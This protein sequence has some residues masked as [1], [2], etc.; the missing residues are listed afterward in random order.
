VVKEIRTGQVIQGTVTKAVDFGVFVDV[1]EGVEGLLHVSEIPG[2]EGAYR[3]LEPGSLIA[4]RVLDINHWRRR[5]SL[6]LQQ[7]SQDSPSP[8]VDE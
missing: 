2:E 7:V 4:V 5:I 1:G 3:D 6:S 8:D